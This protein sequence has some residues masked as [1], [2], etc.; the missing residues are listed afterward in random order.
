MLCVAGSWLKHRDPKGA[1]KFYKALV[2]RCRRTALGTAAD[3]NRWC[4]E[5]DEEGRPLLPRDQR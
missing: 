3:L 2:R 5:L 4:P 1:D